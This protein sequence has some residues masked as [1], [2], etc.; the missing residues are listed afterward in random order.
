[1]RNVYRFCPAGLEYW[2]AVWCSAADTHLKLLDSVVIGDCFSTSGVLECNIA[3]LQS[4]SV[5][6]M[7]SKS[8]CNPMHPLCGAFP[9][10]YIP[11]QDPRSHF[12]AHR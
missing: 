1:M 8:G 2:S 6:C 9:V 11:V 3:H 5:L 10:Q 4:V 12:V 7:L